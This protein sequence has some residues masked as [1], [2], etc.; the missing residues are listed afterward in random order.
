MCDC[1]EV[2]GTCG[3]YCGSDCITLAQGFCLVQLISVQLFF[4]QITT[5]CTEGETCYGPVY[6]MAP[7]W[8]CPLH[9]NGG[10][11]SVEF[12]EGELIYTKIGFAPLT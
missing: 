7:I 12:S 5:H 1:T 11:E 3:V 8:N 9:K 6:A 2:S 4:V 10:W